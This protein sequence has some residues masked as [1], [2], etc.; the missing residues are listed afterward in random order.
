[1]TVRLWKQN[2]LLLCCAAAWA[3]QPIAAQTP[4]SS[5]E[6]ERDL[7]AV[8]M[9]HDTEEARRHRSGARGA[10]LSLPFFDDFSTP[11]MPGPGFEG[12]EAYQRWEPGSARITSTYALN[13]PTIGCATLDGLDRT[14]YPYNYVEVNTPDW[15]DTL[16]S[17]PIALN[18]YFPESNIH[19]M[20]YVQGA[21]GAML[22]IR[23]R[24]VGA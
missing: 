24:R 2:L 20:F 19:L 9:A 6:S 3:L 16:T 10:A 18:G 23:R 22:R 11:S 5:H 15:A 12:Y 8:P 4:A 7:V 17:M 14:G 21:E 1:M 13:A